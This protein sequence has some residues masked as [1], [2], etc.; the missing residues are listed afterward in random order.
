MGLPT[1]I[2][3]RRRGLNWSL[4]LK[5]G[6]DLAIYLFGGFEVLTL[7][8]YAQLV[9][10]GDIALDV[11]AN[12]G[13]HTLPL[14]Q[15]VGPA[16]NVVAFEPTLFAFGKQRTNI[17]LNPELAPRIS[18]HQMMLMASDGDDLPGAAYSSWPLE[19]AAD[20]HAGHH[21]RLM[22]TKGGVGRSLDGILEDLKIGKVDFIKLDVDGNEVDVLAGASATI[23]DSRP[24]IVLELAPYVYE[25]KP[26]RFDSLLERLW[27]SGYRLSNVASGRPLP[28]S[29]R[30]V[31][32]LIPEAGGINV[33]ARFE[34]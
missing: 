23:E 10:P 33:L 29:A 30:E 8:R 19:N 21:G 34:R 5:E 24:L 28:Q 2:V 25:P 7:R 14:A 6:I 1:E 32:R 16:G 15:L 17:A 20:L 11:G 13:A 22:T 27:L 26:E 4:D 12:V 18:T 31:R 9:K 3:V